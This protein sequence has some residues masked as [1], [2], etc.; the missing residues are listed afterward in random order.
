MARFVRS[1]AA[2]AIGKP[3]RQTLLDLSERGVIALFYGYFAYSLTTYFISTRNTSCLV[4]LFSETLVVLMVMARRPATNIS[5]RPQDWALAFVA[6][7]APMLLRPGGIGPHGLSET[8][9]LLQGVGLAAG[10][11]CKLYLF[12]NF[13]VAPALRGLSTHGP[14]KL[15]RHPIYVSYFVAELGYLCAFPT[16][17]NA[18]VLGVW[19]VLQIWRID[20]EE[21]ILRT[22]AAYVAY[23][24]RVQWRLAPGLY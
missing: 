1:A 3:W 19:A 24:R 4:A 9:L 11:W 12:R 21:N 17:R 18:I 16:A 15:V 14:Y 2:A 6:T 7:C 13:G 23:A 5:C 10:L 20:A 8:G 22:N